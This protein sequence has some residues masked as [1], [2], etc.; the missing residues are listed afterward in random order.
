LQ[1]TIEQFLFSIPDAGVALGGL[2]VRSIKYLISKGDLA[3]R[4]IGGRTMVTRESIR[5]YAAGD[6]PEAIR[7]FMQVA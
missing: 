5:R 6:H 1:G 4:K 3:T 2:S 7:P